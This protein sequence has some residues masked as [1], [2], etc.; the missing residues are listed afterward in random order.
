MAVERIVTVKR[1]LWIS[2]CPTCGDRT[3]R[4]EEGSKERMCMKCKVWVPFEKVSYTGP[5]K[6]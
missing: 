4:T 5:D 3:E 1:T 6:F 2:T